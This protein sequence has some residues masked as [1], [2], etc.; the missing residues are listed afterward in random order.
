MKTRLKTERMTITVPVS[1]KRQMGK[2]AEINW[3]AVASK[4]FERHLE[5]Q[6]VVELFAE[7][8]VSD[9]EAIQRGLQLRH[10]VVEKVA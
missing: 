10:K 5:A 9:E 6:R 8:G 3:S 4:A 7:A 1:L 2:R